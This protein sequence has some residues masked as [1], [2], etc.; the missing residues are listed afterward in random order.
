MALEDKI[1]AIAAGEVQILHEEIHRLA[2][3]ILA[4]E[5]RIA[6]EKKPRQRHSAR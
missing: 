6:E 5:A 2:Q 3:R 1:R 4:L